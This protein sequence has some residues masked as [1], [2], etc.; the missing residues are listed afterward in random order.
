MII[1]NPS[2]LVLAAGFISSAIGDTSTQPRRRCA[3]GDRC[4]PDSQIWDNF[5]SSIDGRLIRSMPPASVCHVEEYNASQCRVAKESWLDSS[6]RTNQAGAHS[7]IVWEMGKWGQCGINTPVEAPCDQGIVPYYSV[8]ARCT[9]DIQKTVKFASSKNLLL[10]TKNTGHDHLGRSSGAG[11][12]SI[13]THNLKGIEWHDSFVPQDAPLDVHG[14][15]AVTL[16]AGE[17]WLDVYNAAAERGVLVVGGSARTV[18][19]AGGY[20]LGGGHS[21]FAHFHGLAADNLLE[22][23]IVSADGKY[24]VL[25]AFTNPDYF[26]AIRGGGGS[27]WGVIT[28]VTYRTHKVPDSLLIGFVQLNASSKASYKRVV[29]ESLKV[30]PTVTDAGYTGYG[31]LTGGFT[32]IFVQPNATVASFNQ[33]FLPFFKLSQVPGVSGA[34]AAFPSTWAGYVES[35]LRDPNIGTN[36]QDTSRLLTKDVLNKKA[37]DLADFLYENRDGAGFNFIGKVNNDE[38]DNTAVHDIWKHSHA[39]LSVSTN[40][41]DNATNS[42]KSKKRQHMV[43][44][45]R[46]L[47]KIV[48]KDGGT[49]VNEANPYEPEWEKVF[50]GV[51]YDRL[52]SI[53]NTVDPTN[54]FVCNRCV[55]TDIV[56]QP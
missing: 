51:K 35:F 33:T 25:N 38:R 21:P 53:K 42:E 37:E 26:W 16:Q 10:V 7:A 17:Q 56:L 32:A 41:K 19:A 6:W 4:W 12:L 24:R 5:N 23:T 50:W 28:S 34:V 30:L 27:A 18:G 15:P 40:W 55:G 3:Y 52:L 13:W 8:D 11:A 36:I 48:G 20:V 39:L 54:L 47:T 45:S 14:I 49:Y 2:Q 31:D 29:A 43:W 9:E 22:V 1:P 46:Q 44:L